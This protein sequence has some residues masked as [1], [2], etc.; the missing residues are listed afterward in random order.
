MYEEY[1]GFSKRPFCVTPDPEFFSAS[2]SHR[3][4]LAH[5]RYGV[6]E[7]MGFVV[8]SGEVGTGKTHLVRMLMKELGDDTR[9]ALIVNPALDPEQ[10]FDAVLSD[11]E[12]DVDLKLST[13][14]KLERFVEY[15]IEQNNAGRRVLILIDEAQNLSIPALERLRL[16]SNL[17]TA[18]KKL[19]QIFLIGQPEL[20]LLLNLPV[21][22][23]VRQRIVVRHHLDP[24]T[25]EET[26]AFIRHRLFVVG[27]TDTENIFPKV[28]LRAIHTASGGI[29]RLIN[30]LCD[31]C[32][33]IAFTEECE[34]VSQHMVEEA[35]DLHRSR[36]IISI[37]KQIQTRYRRKLVAP[38]LAAAAMVVFA[39]GLTAWNLVPSSTESSSDVPVALTQVDGPVIAAPTTTEVSAPAIAELPKP[40]APK[41]SRKRDKL[42]EKPS[43][44]IA[45]PALFLPQT[46]TAE[47][48]HSPQ[49]PPS[50]SAAPIPEP[51]VDLPA[52]EPPV[53]LSESEEADIARAKLAHAISRLAGP[54]LDLG[55]EERNQPAPIRDGDALPAIPPLPA[56]SVEQ[57]GVQVA[58]FRTMEKAVE[59][60]DL[61]ADFGPVF[62]V[63][64]HSGKGK[65]WIRVIVGRFESE[66]DAAAC[67]K[68]LK[69]KGVAR[70]AVVVRNA[71]WGDRTQ[72]AS[73]P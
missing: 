2:P 22:R 46:V 21:L 60:A 51:S 18:S 43:E 59:M 48:L 5:L 4:G 53:L 14:E 73:A 10:L 40:P 56:D 11:L 12:V 44:T 1:F 47:P 3:Q 37:P 39:L 68:D 9:R 8:L 65:D 62:L 69:L 23:Q 15:L 72:V 29:P 38:L 66:S 63:E 36:E 67:A 25:L 52:E 19:L 57:Y 61:V 26:E 42:T 17:E 54:I 31:Y 7:G 71:H 13:R 45:A 41:P 33:V 35:I 50:L 30:I 49:T 32:L 16:L 34:T 64:S 6:R 20:D 70:D 24:L 28:A 58:S 55:P 27:G